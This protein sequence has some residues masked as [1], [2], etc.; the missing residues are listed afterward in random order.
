MLDLEIRISLKLGIEVPEPF[1][2]QKCKSGTFDTFNCLFASSDR[3]GFLW[4]LK[5]KVVSYNYTNLAY[6]F[7]FFFNFIERLRVQL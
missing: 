6:V 7:A 2:S 3:P 1:V 5:R 4:N